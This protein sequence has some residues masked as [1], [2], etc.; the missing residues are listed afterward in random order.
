MDD[1]KQLDI[2]ISFSLF[3][4]MIEIKLT[5]DQILDKEI[6]IERKIKAKVQPTLKDIVVKRIMDEILYQEYRMVN[7]KSSYP[8]F[9]NESEAEKQTQEALAFLIKIEEMVKENDI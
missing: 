8:C 4:I 1:K 3:L 9:S 6:D 2:S 5:E 7:R